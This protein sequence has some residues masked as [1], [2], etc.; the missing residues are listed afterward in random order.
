MK[1]KWLNKKVL[2]LFNQETLD[3]LKEKRFSGTLK[4]RWKNGEMVQ[5]RLSTNVAFNKMRKDEELEFD[6][7]FF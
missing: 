2:T 3:K 7:D 1:K 6:T 4:V 5:Y